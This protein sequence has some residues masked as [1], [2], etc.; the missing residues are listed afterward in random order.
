MIV[1]LTLFL[2]S[3]LIYI[4]LNITHI[5]IRVKMELGQFFNKKSI[6]LY[7]SIVKSIIL[8]IKTTIIV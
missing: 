2:P 8:Y 3:N 6:E 7:S 1:V 4:I 5:V